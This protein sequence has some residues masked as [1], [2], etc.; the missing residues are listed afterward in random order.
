M[1]N[2][3][4][5]AVSTAGLSAC[6]STDVDAPMGPAIMCETSSDCDRGAGEVCDEGVCWGGPPEALQFAAVLVPPS[7]RPDL[8]ISE[9]GPLN[10]SDDGTVRGL[11]FADSIHVHGRI[12]LACP[13]GTTPSYPCGPDQSIGAEIT[14]HREATFP[15]GPDL[16]RT[17]VAQANVPPGQDAFSFRLPAN[18]GQYRATIVPSGGEDLDYSPGRLAPPA[19]VSI[20]AQTDQQVEW[21]VGRP[22]TYKHIAGCVEDVVGDGNDFA[23]MRVRALGRWTDLSPLS[24]ASA[25]AQVDSSGCFNVAVPRDMRDTFDLVLSPA[26]GTVKP[27]MRVFGLQVPDPIADETYWIEPALVM[28]SAPSPT[29]FRLPVEATGAAGGQERVPGATVRFDTVFPLPDAEVRNIEVTY[30]AQAVTSGIDSAEPGI[31]ELTLYP[32]GESNR[33]YSAQVVPPPDSPYASNFDLEVAVGLGGAQVLQSVM[34]GRRVAI[35]GLAEDELGQ[36]IADAAIE[37][38]LASLLRLKVEGSPD[39]ALLGQLQSATDTTEEGGG[40]LVWVERQLGGESA[41]YDVTVRPPT[42]S[43]APSWTFESV[44]VPTESNSLDLG[45]LTLPHASRARGIVVDPDGTPVPGAE[46]HLYQLPSG[47]LCGQLQG[48]SDCDPLARL[49]G[50]SASDIDGQVKLLLPDP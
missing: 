8:A 26:A 12:I 21:I 49:R 7:D 19:R 34:L 1:R 14:I 47:D 48:L 5:I 42:P 24:R 27:T 43:G 44:S 38:G 18:A 39:E 50:V 32:G 45:P 4:L 41:S 10:I 25:P 28:P 3:L 35:T 30:S 6:I 20:D 29:V 17:I 11:S 9:I 33:L 16:T 22:G 36:P 31:A 40:F 46:L 15:G 37:A 13:E 23:G 2:L